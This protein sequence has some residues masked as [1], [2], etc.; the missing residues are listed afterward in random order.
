MSLSATT[1]SAADRVNISISRETLITWLGVA[2][3]VVLWEAVAGGLLVGKFIIAPPSAIVGRIAEDLPL[4]G[5]ALGTTLGEAA[6][7]FVFGNVAAIALAIIAVAIPRSERFIKA[8]AL[9]VFCLPLVATG[10][11][12]RVLFGPNWGPQV[13]LA[14]LAVYYTTFVPLVVGLRA[15]PANWIDLVHSYGRGGLTALFVVRIRAAVPYLVAGLQIAA[16]A[17]FLGA[18]VGEFTGADRGMGVLSIQ[19]M[20]SL[21]VEGTWALATIAT[22]V[23][24]GAYATV[25]WIG[26]VLHAGKPPVLLSMAATDSGPSRFAALRSVLV[27]AAIV[28][29]LLLIWQFSMDAFGLNRFFAKRPGDVLAYLVT[30]PTAA[31]NRATLWAALST[32]LLVTL[33]GYLAGLAMGAA[34]AAVFCLFPTVE[35]VVT[36]V[37]L[38]LRSIPI[39]TTA[40]LIVLA[41]GRGPAGMVTIV[42]VMIFFPTL[43]ACLQGLRQTPGQVHDVFDSYATSRFVKLW[44]AQVPAMLPAFFAAARMAV[45]AAVLSATVAEWLA[46]GTGI[47]N[48]M[49]LTNSTSNYNMLWSCVAVLTLLSV[50]GYWLVSLVE[51]RILSRFAPEQVSA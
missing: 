34:L 33:P 25:G 13:T 32:T 23:T 2:V 47:G 28:A 51:R 38:A 21:D 45:P 22:I 20:R 19:T 7:G 18:M 36:P 6:L 37:A 12:L 9:V 39:V 29:A 24:V 50:A 31:D 40:P 5:R 4:F 8:L 35:R 43:V 48:L 1:S 30:G 44:Q 17:A 41:M 16:P 14:A 27:F 15:V 10:P 26:N 3:L 49:A 46:T 11:V 42:A